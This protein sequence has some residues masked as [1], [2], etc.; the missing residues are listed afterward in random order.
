MFKVTLPQ[1]MP[2][3]VMFFTIQVGVV[4][5]A[6]FDAILL[7]PYTAVLD[8]SDTLFTYT[9]RMAFGMVP[10]YGLSA[11]SNLF[12]SIVG[13]AMLFGANALSRK[14]AKMSLF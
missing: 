11:A 6:G 9:Y 3:I 2:L 10:D 7:L 1:L 13:T 8:V 4:F 5:R 12:Q 14:T